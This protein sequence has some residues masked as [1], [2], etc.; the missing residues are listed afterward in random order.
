MVPGAVTGTSGPVRLLGLDVAELRAMGPLSD[1]SLSPDGSR[2]AAVAGGRAVAGAVVVEPNGTA[3]V[4]HVR[5][6]RP[7]EMGQA[8]ALDW[9]ATDQLVVATNTD[10]PIQLVSVDGL[11]LDRLPSVNLTPP[12]RAVA[13]APGR[14]PYL[15]ADRTGV[16]SYAGGDLDAWQQ[17]L[18]ATSSAQ[19]F[20]PG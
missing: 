9:R 11:T 1:L 4:R 5:T 7:A 19:P 20:Y 6:L 17:M 12:L 2:V 16:W 18:G 3:A 13:A 8:V 15:V 14:S 10:Q